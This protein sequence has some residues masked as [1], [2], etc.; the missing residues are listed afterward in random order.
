MSSIPPL[1]R[2]SGKLTLHFRVMPDGAEGLTAELREQRRLE[3]GR[4]LLT[5]SLSKAEIA[6]RVGVSR[7]AVTQWARLLKKRRRG[8]AGLRS[9]RHTGRPAR[10]TKADWRRVVALLRR[11]PQAAGFTSDR[12]TLVR[13][14]EL[15]QREFGVS[16]GKSY[17]AD[18]LYELGWP[19]ELSHPEDAVPEPEIWWLESRPFTGYY[20]FS[21]WR[22][23]YRRR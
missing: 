10:L 12:W 18:K 7:S 8:L 13:I 2:I 17:L 6:R 11:G 14:R 4:L 19:P 3:A 5:T 22:R 1:L 16:Y 9:R 23:W 21:N 20:N 15:I